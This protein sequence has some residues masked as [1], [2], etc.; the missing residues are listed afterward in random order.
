MYIGNDLQIAHPSYKIIDDISSGFNGSTTSFALQVNGETPVPFPISTQQVMISV[1]GVVQEPDPSGSAG[2]KLLGSN[3][4]FSSAPANG[5]AFFGVINAGA[6]YVTAGS[7]FPDGSVTSPSFT[8]QDDQDTGWYRSGSGAVSYSSNGVNTIGF[9]G[10]G[11]TVTGDASFVGDSAKN[12][13]WD[14]S[15]GRLE[16]A[17]NA[18][19]TF[20]TGDDLKIFHNATNSEIKNA[21]G[22]L[23]LESDGTWI[24]DKE[25][26]D[27]MAKF[28]HDGAVELYFDNAK[29]LSTETWG[30][31]IH[32]VLAT[33]SHVDIAA[34]NAQL[35]VGAGADLKLYNDG[36]NSYIDNLTGNDLNIRSRNIYFATHANVGAEAALNLNANGSVELY[37]DNVKTFET[38]ANGVQ[39]F[40]SEGNDAYIGLNADE[41]DDTSDKWLLTAT[42]GSGF[43]LSGLNAG[44]SWETS[45]KAVTDGAV[46]LYHNNEL[47]AYTHDAGFIVKTAGDTDSKL[48]VI[49]PEG[50]NAVISLAADDADDYPDIWRV[51]A[52]TS[53]NFKI[54]TLSTGSYVDGLTL[55]GSANATFGGTVSDSKGNLRSIPRDNKSSAYVLVATDAG[56]CISIT[57]GGITI[58]T[59]IFSNGDAVTILNHSG[60][61]QTITA[62]SGFALFNS[63]DA[64]TGN[65]TLAGRGM[66]TVYFVA[67]DTA[68][69]SGA[70][71]S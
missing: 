34:D 65:R 68:Y 1:N 61:D 63:A 8:F 30:C 28:L 52:D 42:N 47:Q 23:Y 41:G 39:V 3:I 19:A 26:S 45:L 24:T 71:L 21:T 60:S 36:S 16:F 5:H 54:S 7:E 55:D 17:D 2:F 69:V 31:Q 14:K 35:K 40:G 53:G 9:D 12:L 62:G 58:N 20:G 22:T 70:G 64:A 59:S 4:V 50:R 43:T 11:L 48:Q 56:K 49:G 44:G 33:T 38:I 32:G 66:C 6:D 15:D 27:K 46:E 67:N 13:L 57:S 37:Y 25:G 18:Q 29:K 51:Q 10:N